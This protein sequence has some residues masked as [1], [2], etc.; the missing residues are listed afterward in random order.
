MVKI[1]GRFQSFSLTGFPAVKKG[2]RQSLKYNRKCQSKNHRNQQIASVCDAPGTI[3]CGPS[4][5]GP[6]CRNIIIH[7]LSAIGRA[8]SQQNANATGDGCSASN[9]GVAAAGIAAAVWWWRRLGGEVNG[10]DS[11]QRFY[12]PFSF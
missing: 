6:V 10:P 4:S 2:L 12:S 3:Q 9:G 1:S 5:F 11:Y 7:L 8:Q